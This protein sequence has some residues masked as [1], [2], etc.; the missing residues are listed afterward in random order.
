VVEGDFK[1]EIGTRS[2][3]IVSPPMCLSGEVA[4][5]PFTA[6]ATNRRLHS[7]PELASWSALATSK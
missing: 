3:A 2:E 5:K 6:M 7:A 4:R 1:I